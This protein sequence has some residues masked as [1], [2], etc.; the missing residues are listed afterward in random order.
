MVN[1]GVFPIVWGAF[2]TV[3]VS[4]CFGKLLFNSLALT[5]SRVE[6]D[7]LAFVTG[8]ACVST[9]VFF[10]CVGHVGRKGAFTIMVIGVILIAVKKKAL[11]R[12]RLQLPAVNKTWMW[13][14]AVPV[15][16][17]TWVYFLMRLPQKS[18]LMGRPIIWEMLSGGGMIEALYAIR[19]VCTQ[20]FPRAWRCCF[21][22][23]IPMDDT[24]LPRLFTSVF[25]PPCRGSYGAMDDASA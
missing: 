22:S 13:A 3:L 18:V 2:L 16:L 9:L 15:S 23:L 21:L 6:E 24:Q 12:S 17:Y 25:W 1:A 20:T 5:F 19:E 10:L 8:A 14:I 11:V 4:W 7:L